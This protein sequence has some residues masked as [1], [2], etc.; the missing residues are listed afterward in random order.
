MIDSTPNITQNV[1]QDPGIHP[2]GIT[3]RPN[4]NIN[5]NINHNV[6]HRFQPSFTNNNLSSQTLT[7]LHHNYIG[8]SLN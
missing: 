8:N 2:I 1:S 5:F 3:D 6:P 7:Q 4:N